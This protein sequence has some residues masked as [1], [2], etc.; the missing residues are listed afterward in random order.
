[1]RTTERIITNVTHV[2]NLNHSVLYIRLDFFVKFETN[3]L[4]SIVLWSVFSTAHSY[5]GCS[6]ALSVG[7]LID[8]CAII[9]HKPN[10]FTYVLLFFWLKKVI[11]NGIQK[12]IK[13]LKTYFV[14]TF[15]KFKLAF[16]LKKIKRSTFWQ[17]HFEFYL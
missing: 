9:V 1:M 3:Q 2:G 11:S 5:V 12:N 13:L 6:R 14:Q 15:A 17:R 16:N 8:R 7:V 4:R 10:M